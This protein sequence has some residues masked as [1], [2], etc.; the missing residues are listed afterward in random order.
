MTIGIVLLA[1]VA[2]MAWQRGRGGAAAPPTAAPTEQTS[3]TPPTHTTTATEVVVVP[4]TTQGQAVVTSTSV[5]RPTIVRTSTPRPTR[6]PPPP[7]T[8][9]PTT[10]AASPNATLPPSRPTTP[11]ATPT[12]LAPHTVRITL[13]SPNEQELRGAK[14]DFSITVEGWQQGDKLMLRLGTDPNLGPTH[15]WSEMLPAGRNRFV[16]TV[17]DPP[18]GYGRDYWWSV[19]VVSGGGSATVTNGPFKVRWEA[20]ESEEGSVAPVPAHESASGG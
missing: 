2:G 17:Y 10:P 14:H 5:S 9:A 11:P 8:A 15:N 19:V 13:L 4:P 18:S 20:P 7:P 3:L 6:T 16:T 12:P 1:L